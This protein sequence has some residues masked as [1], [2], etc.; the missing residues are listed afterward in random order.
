M[1]KGTVFFG[2]WNLVHCG[3]EYSSPN[4]RVHFYAEPKN[5]SGAWRNV[6]E[7]YFVDFATSENDPYLK[8][9]KTDKVA[10]AYEVKLIEFGIIIISFTLW[11][12]FSLLTRNSQ[13]G[14]L[15]FTKNF[16]NRI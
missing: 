2:K 5:T 10:V 15:V 16:K 3:S 1:K 8:R 6:D 7:V 4:I 12:W 11:F 9:N 14:M 13:I